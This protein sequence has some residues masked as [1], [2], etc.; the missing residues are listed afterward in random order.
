MAVLNPR[1]RLV[2][3][4]VSEEEF[5]ALNRVCQSQGAR[6]LSVLMRSAMQGMIDGTHS[7][8]RGS[9]ADHLR[10]VDGRLDE[11]RYELQRLA[12]LIQANILTDGIMTDGVLT[13][14][15][16]GKRTAAER[17]NGSEKG[18]AN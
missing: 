6:S 12:E 10:D 17:V 7:N 18:R 4:R 14:G 11:L 13:D 1:S 5:Q 2:Y 15:D 9:V 3:F 16:G 8:E